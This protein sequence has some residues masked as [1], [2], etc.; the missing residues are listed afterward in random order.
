MAQ[1]RRLCV[2]PSSSVG[3]QIRVSSKTY[4]AAECAGRVV[5]RTTDLLEMMAGSAGITKVGLR[6]GK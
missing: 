4:D 2:R 1:A 3:F 5:A 6:E